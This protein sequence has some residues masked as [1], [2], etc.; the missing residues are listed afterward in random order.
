MALGKL[1]ILSTPAFLSAFLSIIIPL[2]STVMAE[3]TEGGHVTSVMSLAQVFALERNRQEV[4][5]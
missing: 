5:L 4:E 3:A 2:N 1:F